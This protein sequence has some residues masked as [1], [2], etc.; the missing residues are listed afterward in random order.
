[1]RVIEIAKDW[2]GRIERERAQAFL[3]FLWRHFRD[4]RCL[5]VAGALSYTT[6]FALVPLATAVFG[7]LSA[8]PVFDELSDSLMHFVFENFV[9]GSA[10]AVENYLLEFAEAAS[11]LTMLGVITLLVIALWTMASIESTFN[12]IW[13]VRT[14]RPAVMRFLVYW[15]VLTLGALM[16]V[17]VLAATSYVFGLATGEQGLADWF[18]RA[19][20]W[21]VELVAFSLAYIVIPNRTVAKRHALAGGAL[22]TLLFEAAKWGFAL[23]LRNATYQQIYGALAVLP[24]FLFW[25]YLSWLV[26]LLGATF[27]AALSAFRYQPASMRLP[28]GYELFGMLR[29]LGRL[30]QARRRGRG[31]HTD[32]LHLLE[33]CLTDDMLQR[34]LGELVAIGVVS[35]SEHGEWLLARDLEALTLGELYEAGNLRIP[36]AEARLPCRSDALGRAAAGALDQLRLPLRDQL[37]RSVASMLPDH[38]DPSPHVPS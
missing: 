5:D 4:D 22:A 38:E 15:T 9:P 8:F 17:A 7:I 27:A 14:A 36:V 12:Q 21:G 1:M 25:L 37:R 19:V 33:P 34:M 28:A 2:A 18:L 30:Q 26:V 32:M 31:L 11:R 35:R 23:Y 16:A 20:P 6:V 24:I 29:L 10:R 13:R 3:V